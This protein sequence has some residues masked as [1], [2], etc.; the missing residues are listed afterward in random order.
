[1]PRVRP[2]ERAC[3]HALARITRS[4]TRAQNACEFVAQLRMRAV[5][6]L[7]NT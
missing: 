1:M 2:Q 6:R 7:I 5:L 3:V 4:C